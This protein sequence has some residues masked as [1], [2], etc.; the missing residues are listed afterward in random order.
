MMQFLCP[1][2]NI[3]G[4]EVFIGY[5]WTNQC[6]WIGKLLGKQSQVRYESERNEV[7]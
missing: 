2:W 1:T 3:S 5:K 7:S 6:G 4:F